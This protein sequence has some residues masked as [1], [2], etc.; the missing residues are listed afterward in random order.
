MF[1]VLMGHQVVNDV[2]ETVGPYKATCISKETLLNIL[3]SHKNL[4]GLDIRAFSAAKDFSYNYIC[5]TFDDGFKEYIEN[6]LPIAEK[7]EIPCIIFLTT[8]YID[9]ELIPYEIELATI[10]DSLEKIITPDGKSYQTNTNKRKQNVYESIRLPLK[11]VTNQHR[12]KYLRELIR[13]NNC[14]V[15]LR[16]NI[17]FL[18][19][20]DIVALDRH[21]LI[22]IGAHTHTHPY[23]P[24]LSFRSAFNEIKKPKNRIEKVLGHSIDCF[25]YPYGGHSLKIRILA[26]LS[27]FKYAFTTESTPIKNADY[28]RMAIPRIDMNQMVTNLD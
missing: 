10:I 23:L 27:G 25:S 24:A 9:N 15:V 6:V 21:P 8:G 1:K 14:S 4:T 20:E 16:Q 13:I 3:E 26:R 22:R 5:L 2:K 18:T 28:N 7:F 19:W 12:Q 17:K 11:M